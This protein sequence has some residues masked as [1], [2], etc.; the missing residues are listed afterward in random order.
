MRDMIIIGTTMM[1]RKELRAINDEYEIMKRELENTEKIC[2]LNLN[3]KFKADI[4]VAFK[5][6][7]KSF[8][9]NLRMFRD[10]S[11]SSSILN[12]TN[13]WKLKLNIEKKILIADYNFS[14]FQNKITMGNRYEFISTENLGQLVKNIFPNEDRLSHRFK[15]KIKNLH[16]LPLN[17]IHL[18]KEM[19]VINKIPWM[20]SFELVPTGFNNQKDFNLSIEP[21]IEGQEPMNSNISFT[22]ID[23]N[24]VSIKDIPYKL[25][26]LGKYGYIIHVSFDDLILPRYNIYDPERQSCIF[27]LEIKIDQ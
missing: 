12:D 3:K 22:F 2:K 8:K 18:I 14:K 9:E 1:R 17:R 26:T 24:H 13:L 11:N 6:T 19:H 10:L 15:L 5:D 20:F 25:S 27:D 21:E 4:K 23:N 16:K 7:I